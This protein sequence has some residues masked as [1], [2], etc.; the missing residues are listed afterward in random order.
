[1]LKNEYVESKL[2]FYVH[3]ESK[4]TEVHF[5]MSQ[6]SER[7]SIFFHSSPVSEH[8]HVC[9]IQYVLHKVYV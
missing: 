2:T 1:M 3:T 7:I 9:T 8:T 6:Q 5:E 4:Q